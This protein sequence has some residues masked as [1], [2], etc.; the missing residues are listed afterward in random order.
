MSTDTPPYFFSETQTDRTQ[1]SERQRSRNFTLKDLDWFDSVYLTTL[2][3]PSTTK[4][5]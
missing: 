1:L 2:Y 3:C 4:C 5:F